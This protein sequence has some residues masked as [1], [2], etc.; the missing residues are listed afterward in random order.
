[1]KYEIELTDKEYD[2]LDDYLTAMYVNT[3]CKTFKDAA[4]TIRKEGEINTEEKSKIYQEGYVAGIENTSKEFKPEID[5]II[6]EKNNAYDKALEDVRDYILSGDMPE[7]AF[8][9]SDVEW[10]KMAIEEFKKK[11]QKFKVGDV[12]MDDNERGIVTGIFYTATGIILSIVHADGST[13]TLLESDVMSTGRNLKEQ[14]IQLLDEIE[15]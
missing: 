12:V 3:D 11:K 1:M 8:E 15:D 6:E 9:H 10:I 4:L 5:R 14:V 7:G 2:I 13:T